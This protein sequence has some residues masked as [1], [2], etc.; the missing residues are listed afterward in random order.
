MHLKLAMC[1]R[2]ATA[3]IAMHYLPCAAGLRLDADGRA[4]MTGPTKL[5]QQFLDMLSKGEAGGKV[6]YACMCIDVGY[7]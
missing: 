3:M 7:F 6:V 2:S 4:R 1:M 5:V